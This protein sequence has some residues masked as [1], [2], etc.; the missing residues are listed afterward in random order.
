VKSW[1]IA[2]ASASGTISSIPTSISLMGKHMRR[3][4][5]SVR[6]IDKGVRFVP[7]K[8]VAIADGT[9]ARCSADGA[10]YLADTVTH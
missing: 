2:Q 7:A 10:A 8:R 5:V 4:R 1:A 9:T 6:P 3:R